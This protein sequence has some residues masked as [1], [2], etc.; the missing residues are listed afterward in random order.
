MILK[1]KKGQK[2]ISLLLVVMILLPSLVIF[3]TPKKVEAFSDLPAFAQR[4]ITFG[5]KLF[6]NV[7]D[8]VTAGSTTSTTVIKGKEFAKDLLMEVAKAAA[9]KALQEVTKSTINWINTGYHGA[10]LF[11]ENPESFFQ[12]IAKWEVRTLVDRY[13]YDSLKFPFGKDFALSTIN[14]YRGRLEETRAYSL[15]NYIT[16]PVALSNYQN[17]FNVGGWDGFFLNTQ[18]PQNN[19]MGFQLEATDELARK[20]QGTSITAKEK[21]QQTLDQGM[22]FLS[23]Q[24]CQ[25]NPGYN[26]LK[27]EFN[28]PSFDRASY[29]K[30]YMENMPYC[31]DDNN[32]TEEELA[33][34]KQYREEY[35]L[36][37][38]AARQKWATTN[39]CPPRRDGSSGLVNTT[40]GSVVAN[41]IIKSV[42]APSTLKEHAINSG[43]LIVSAI[44]DQ[45]INKFVDKGL[46]SL[47]SAINPDEPEDEWS[48]NGLTLG[49][50]S[51]IVSGYG[52][53][54]DAGPDEVVTVSDLKIMLENDI[55]KTES[56][57]KHMTNGVPDSF[58]PGTMQVF[59]QIWPK[60]QEL[61]VCQPGPDLGWQARIDLEMNKSIEK[62]SS[63]GS[64]DPSGAGTVLKE[65]EFAVSF[66][67]DWT[68]TQLKYALPS[69]PSFMSAIGNL[70]DLSQQALDIQRK[71]DIK[72][73]TLAQL[74]IMKTM[75]DA[76]PPAPAEGSDD[77][78]KLLSLWTQHKSIAAQ[79][80]NDITL[81]E[82]KSERDIALGKTHNLDQLLITCKEERVAKGW[83]VQGGAQSKLSA[84]G[85]TEQNYFCDGPILGGYSH[86][87]F[88]NPD[89]PAYPQ[90]P[91]V[92]ASNVQAGGSSVDIMLNCSTIFN[93][94][95][96]DYKG[97]LPGF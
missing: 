60:V 28:A 30:K 8:A 84:R 49:G 48:Y 46:S 26:N 5:Q 7:K 9:M 22:G 64:E 90:I 86:K 32:C 56:E 3:S 67:K 31:A 14:A 62:M 82:A 59:G 78:D 68:S 51:A 94:N 95:L 23:P 16:D 45:L 80:T 44:F 20:I 93:A 35:T 34:I 37:L 85:A 61:D 66:F 1:N 11:L 17:D 47:A 19:P 13:G 43:S 83:E 55:D 24:I 42:Q 75:L 2:F 63:A 27:N 87:M 50:G 53:P 57:I 25:T 33:T 41:Q 74:K 65:L 29:E 96:L 52:D 54:W 97:D 79:I 91:L 71:I 88:V 12:D 40:P 10:P 70:G 6:S 39:T 58:G 4:V 69:S 21:V 81:N 72:E 73:D 15:S 18:F 92:N 38:A 36:G 77:E 89:E 76:L